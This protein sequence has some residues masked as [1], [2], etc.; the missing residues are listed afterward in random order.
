MLVS[1]SYA[2]KILCGRR[3]ETEIAAAAAMPLPDE[4]E[5]GLMD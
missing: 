3:I 5:D 1:S 4:D 2:G